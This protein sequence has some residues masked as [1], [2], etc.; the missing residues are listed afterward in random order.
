MKMFDSYSNVMV[1]IT[2]LARKN[3]N[4]VLKGKMLNSIPGMFYLRPEEV[5]SAIRLLSWPVIRYLPIMLIKGWWLSKRS[6]QPK[7]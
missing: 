5:W 2:E 4:L 1:D 7:M 6:K 3:D